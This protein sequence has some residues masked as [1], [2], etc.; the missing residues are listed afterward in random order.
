MEQIYRYFENLITSLRWFGN[1][2]FGTPPQTLTVVFDTGS[3]TAVSVFNQDFENLTVRECTDTMAILGLSAPDVPLLLITDQTEGFD[4]DPFSGIV[5]MAFRP[6]QTIFSLFLT[7]KIVGNAELTLG[8]ID[9]SKVNGTLIFSPIVLPHDGSDG[10]LWMLNSSTIIV[11]NQSSPILQKPLEI[12]FDSGTSNLVFDSNITKAIYQL[13]SPNIKPHGTLGA[14]GLPC[15]EIGSVVAD[16]SFTFTNISGNPFVLSVPSEEFN[17]GPFD[18]DP[19]TCQT[20]INALDGFNIIGG[21]LL[22]HYYSVWDVDHAQLG[23]VIPPD[24]PLTS[25]TSNTTGVSAAP[26]SGAYLPTLLS[27]VAV[28]LLSMTVV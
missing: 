8:G 2:S 26:A 24:Q 21:S 25:T 7:P 22:K 15:S 12:I 27:I 4:I 13:I 6:N 17:L 20:L 5:G 14:F 3:G 23:F 16:I 18:D 11:N 28:L 19:T 9:E 10:S 1:I